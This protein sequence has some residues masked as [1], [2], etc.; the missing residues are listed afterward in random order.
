MLH[1][2]RG[3]KWNFRFARSQA[4]LKE[5]NKVWDYRKYATTLTHFNSRLI[6]VVC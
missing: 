1:T 5:R 3:L 6:F 2:A 4:N